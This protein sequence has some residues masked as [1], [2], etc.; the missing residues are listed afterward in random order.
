ML[1]AF[2]DRNTVVACVVGRERS[3]VLSLANLS[4]T[5]RNGSGHEIDLNGDRYHVT[6]YGDLTISRVR[7]T[8]SGEYRCNLTGTGSVEPG[9]RVVHRNYT[10]KVLG[11][12]M[13]LCA[14]SYARTRTHTHT[15]THTHMHVRMHARMYARMCARMYTHT[16][17]HIHV[18]THTHAR[19]HARTHTHTHTHTHARTHTRARL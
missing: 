8:D 1:V 19:T 11:R 4:F 14:R 7:L 15:H 12:Y 6:D 16:H 13:D 2:R 17:T 3:I 18:H 5:W 9:D 10:R